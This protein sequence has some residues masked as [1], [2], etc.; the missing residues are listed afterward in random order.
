MRK[1]Y[2]SEKEGGK[3]LEK[4][5]GRHESANWE[6]KRK[7]KKKRK[8]KREK[9]VEGNKG[10]FLETKT[11]LLH[12]YK[13]PQGNNEEMARR[14]RRVDGAKAK[15]STRIPCKK[16]KSNQ[17]DRTGI[18]SGDG[19]HKHKKNIQIKRGLLKI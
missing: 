8:K 15:K 3:G 5:S 7:T 1:K 18:H 17:E 16:K 9:I 10:Y 13:L 14:S 11:L 19:D 2:R 4:K 12:A 6:E